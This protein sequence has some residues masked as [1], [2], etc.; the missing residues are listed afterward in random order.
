MEVLVLYANGSLK[1]FIFLKIPH[2]ITFLTLRQRCRWVIT[3]KSFCAFRDFYFRQESNHFPRKESLFP[4]NVWPKVKRRKL[5]P[6]LNDSRWHEQRDWFPSL[7]AT[8]GSIRTVA[9]WKSIGYIYIYICTRWK[10]ADR[11]N[12]SGRLICG[13][14]RRQLICLLFTGSRRGE[15][16]ERTRTVIITMRNEDLIYTADRLEPINS[17]TITSPRFSMKREWCPLYGLAVC[18]QF[19]KLERISL[20]VQLSMCVSHFNVNQYLILID[21][22]FLLFSQYSLK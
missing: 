10:S 16:N 2:R 22:T 12:K 20:F 3:Y 21:L 5:P 1:I 18:G 9:L 6:R 7:F 19:K 4:A 15:N 8:A 13:P 14:G 11:R 17:V